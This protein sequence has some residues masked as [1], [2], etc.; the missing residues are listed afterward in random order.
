MQL[1]EIAPRLGAAGLLTCPFRET[2]TVSSLQRFASE[3]FESTRKRS[4]IRPGK[5]LV[6]WLA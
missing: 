1:P 2:I 5:S 6:R 3:S 4:H